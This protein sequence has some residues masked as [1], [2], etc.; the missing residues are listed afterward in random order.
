MGQGPPRSLAPL[1][2][3]LLTAGGRAPP[4]G[5]RARGLVLPMHL[6]DARDRAPP[7]GLRACGLALQGGSAP[8]ASRRLGGS[9]PS[10]SRRQGGSAPAAALYP[11]ASPAAPRE[12]S[13]PWVCHSFDQG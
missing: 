3:G 11:G 5:L 4:R 6:L 2:R 1:I 9:S 13:P 10:A 7:K 12:P 8:E